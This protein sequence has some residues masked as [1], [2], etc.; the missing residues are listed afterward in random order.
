LQELESKT[1][2]GNVWI[3]LQGL[4]VRKDFSSCFLDFLLSS[5]EFTVELISSFRKERKEKKRKIILE[6]QI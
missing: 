6:K 5:A 2:E 3:I 1:F 4:T